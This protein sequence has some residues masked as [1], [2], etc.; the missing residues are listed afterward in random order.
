V[1]EYSAS[2]ATMPFNTRSLAQIFLI[3]TSLSITSQNKSLVFGHNVHDYMTYQLVT[4]KIVHQILAQYK[5]LL[6]VSLF[7]IVKTLFVLKKKF[8]RHLLQCKGYMCTEAEFLDKIQTKA[9][10]VFLLAI[11]SRLS[12]ALPPDFCFFKL[13]QPLTVSTV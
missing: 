4:I 3:T 11:Q 8:R 10:R 9:L 6:K 1:T 7:S 5:I 2:G 13:T 12:T